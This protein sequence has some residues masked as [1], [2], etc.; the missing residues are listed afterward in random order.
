MMKTSKSD[1][2]LFFNNDLR[3]IVFSWHNKIHFFGSIL[4]GFFLGFG[5]TYAIGLGWEIKDGV[6]PWWDDER[7]TEWYDYPVWHWKR[8][9]T[10]IYLSD[11]FSFQDAFVWDLSGAII[12]ALIRALVFRDLGF[13]KV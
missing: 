10:Y 1:R 4:G 8:I 3:R 9:A 2:P 12:G 11:K 13:G 5:I 6:G 7:F